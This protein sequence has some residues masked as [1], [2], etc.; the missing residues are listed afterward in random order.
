MKILNTSVIALSASLFIS[1]SVFAQGS[2]SGYVGQT[3]YESPLDSATSYEIAAGYKF[4]N[5]FTVG[6]SYLNL[7][8]SSYEYE[9]AGIPELYKI[10]VE[11]DG[12]NLSVAGEVPLGEAFGIY[13]KLGYYTWDAGSDAADGNDLNYGI[14]ANWYFTEKMNLNLGYTMYELADSDASNF[15]LGLGYSF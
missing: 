1:T 14:G 2:I 5:F 4:A 9:E 11:V 3:D 10:D 7:G 12:F 6:L 15:S 13:A 8:S